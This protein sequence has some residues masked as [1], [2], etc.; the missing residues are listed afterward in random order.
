METKYGIR[1]NIMVVGSAKSNLVTADED[2]YFD[3]DYNI[4]FTNLPQIFCSNLESLRARVRS[5]FDCIA[6]NDSGI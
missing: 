1:A 2:G 6:G 4:C 5:D 3:L